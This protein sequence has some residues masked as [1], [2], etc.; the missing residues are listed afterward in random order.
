MDS[1]AALQLEKIQVGIMDGN[2]FRRRNFLPLIPSP[3]NEGVIVAFGV[4]LVCLCN[5]K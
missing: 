5:H 3:V 1:R 2:P 4:G